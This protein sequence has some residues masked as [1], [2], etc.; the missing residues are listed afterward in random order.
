MK[1]GLFVSA[2]LSILNCLQNSDSHYTNEG[3]DHG[4]GAAGIC[5]DHTVDISPAQLHFSFKEA[6]LTRKN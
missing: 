4:C 1:A 5:V 2:I 3:L 6:Y